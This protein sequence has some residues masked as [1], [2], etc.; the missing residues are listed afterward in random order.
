MS[1]RP[2][3]IRAPVA[4][5]TAVVLMALS[6]AVPLLDQGRHGGGVALAETG[7]PAGYVDHHH[8]VCLQHGAAA[9]SPAR[10]ADLPAGV[11]VQESDTPRDAARNAGRS[12]G[13]PHHP[14]APPLV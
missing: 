2:R 4:V 6:V 3:A 7:A 13:S 14:R 10:G 12:A 9:W 5:V 8:G 1:L 11:L